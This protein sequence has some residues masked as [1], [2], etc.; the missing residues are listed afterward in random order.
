MVAR[1]SRSREALDGQRD[2]GF[3]LMDVLLV[4]LIFGVLIAALATAISA[5]IRVTPGTE[6]RIDDA[7]STRALSTYL[8]HDT[9]STPPFSPEQAQG[10]F[11]VDSVANPDNN[12]CGRPGINIV[13]MQWT[14]SAPGTVTYVA[15]YR[16]VV[17]GAVAR[18]HRSVCSS[19][20]GDPFELRSSISVTVAP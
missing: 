4:V 9:T 2:A 1:S 15:N 19:E 12:D 5:A 17:D 8:S 3:T 10:G 6:D 16:F 20:G 7:R 14:E 18:V 13:H 11:D